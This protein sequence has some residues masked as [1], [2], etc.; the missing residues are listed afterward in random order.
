MEGTYTIMILHRN[1][2]HVMLPQGNAEV[3]YETFSMNR[4]LEM[5]SISEEIMQN[6]VSNLRYLT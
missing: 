5:Q 3:D 1:S 6:M 2:F 4:H